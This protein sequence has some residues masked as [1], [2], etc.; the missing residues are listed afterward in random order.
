[1]G[2]NVVTDIDDLEPLPLGKVH[3]L[4]ALN[5]EQRMAELRA[6]QR[7]LVAAA[8][9]IRAADPQHEVLA[10][11]D[12]A[13]KDVSAALVGWLATWQPESGPH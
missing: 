10:T 2:G 9:R 3:A 5:A 7:E 8:G 13:L 1:V 12:Q 6:K 11:A 4:I